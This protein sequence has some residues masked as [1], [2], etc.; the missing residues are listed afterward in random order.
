MTCDWM[1]QDEHAFHVGSIYDRN[2]YGNE[3]TLQLMTWH[4]CGLRKGQTIEGLEV[5]RRG[6]LFMVRMQ[7]SNVKQESTKLQN[8]SE[9]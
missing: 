3:N 2:Y 1:V 6:V 8:R 7:S 9:Q 4:F 5:G